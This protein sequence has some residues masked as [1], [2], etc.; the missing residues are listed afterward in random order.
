[1]LNASAALIEEEFAS[2][3]NDFMPLLLEIAEKAGG[4]TDAQWPLKARAIESIGVL[5]AAVADN[6]EFLETVQRVTAGLVA[7]LASGFAEDD[8]R[9]LAVKDTL[10]KV[11]YYLK[12][13]F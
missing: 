6:R 4:A 7:L 13:D 1:M 3:F 2:H 5:I 10:A 11:A 12:D 9:H 8:P